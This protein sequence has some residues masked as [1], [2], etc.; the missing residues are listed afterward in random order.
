MRPQGG[1]GRLGCTGSCGLQASQLAYTKEDNIDLSPFRRNNKVLDEMII[2][3]S[4]K[5][6]LSMI[7]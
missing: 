5:D 6:G 4:K 1:S 7:T 2:Q 3:N